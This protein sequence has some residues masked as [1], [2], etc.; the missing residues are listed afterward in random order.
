MSGKCLFYSIFFLIVCRSYSQDIKIPEENITGED[1]RLQK[2]EIFIKD[3]PS[4]EIVFPS[5]PLMPEKDVSMQK[6]ED[7]LPF[8]E[9]SE[10]DVSG[11]EKRSLS[12]VVDSGKSAGICLKHPFPGRDVF[13]MLNIQAFYDSGYRDN[14]ELS[15]IQLGYFWEKEFSRFE[16]GARKGFLQLP[17]PVHSPLEMEREYLALDAVYLHNWT[18]GFLS[19]INQAFYNIEGTEI[20]YAELG[21]SL[22]KENFTFRTEA[23]RY[24]VFNESFSQTSFYQGL[25]WRGKNAAIGGGIKTITGHSVKFLPFFEF[26]PASDFILSLRGFYE[27]PNLWEDLISSNYKEIRDIRLAPEEEYRF[28]AAFNREN[29]RTNIKASFAQSYI[30]NGY[31]WADMD[32]NGLLEPVPEE[33][34]KTSLNL[35]FKQLLFK[36]VSLFFNGEK[37]FLSKEVHYF[38]EERLDAGFI[39]EFPSAVFKLWASHEGD[40]LFVD[41]KSGGRT[42]LNAELKFLNNENT[43]W[44]IGVYNLGGGKHYIVPGYPA[45]H[46]RVF[47]FL[48]FSF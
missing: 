26:K 47:G 11:K 9:P 4:S 22:G 17:G 46:R 21:L 39:C 34:W 16:A 27:T 5:V 41:G 45:E 24:D 2:S 7:E 37:N 3:M 1:L 33:Y 15:R 12:F 29:A 18:P 8:E 6:G 36:D 44:G 31:T 40:K 42:I 20:N 48:R 35:D 10:E 32:A 43:E 19:E 13:R 14:D 38:T 25:S 30:K 28:E 23:E